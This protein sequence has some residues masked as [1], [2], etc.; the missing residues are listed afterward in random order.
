MAVKSRS[1]LPYLVPKVK[2]DGQS[3]LYYILLLCPAVSDYGGC[4]L[5]SY[6]LIA[7]PVNT[8]VLAFLSAVAGDALTRHLGVILAA[9]L[10][11]LKGKLG[12]EDEA[13]V[14]LAFTGYAIYSVSAFGSLLTMC[15][16]FFR[17]CATVKQ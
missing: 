3:L 5:R 6:Q 2:A 8:R 12:T 11:S 13:Q 17:C 9:L 15:C 10:S 7:P 14:M 1:V 16:L 4:S